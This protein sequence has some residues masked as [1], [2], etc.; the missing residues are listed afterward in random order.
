MNR[1]SALT[2]TL[3][4]ATF[5]ASQFGS[6]LPPI[7][8]TRQRADDPDLRA[9]EISLLVFAGL[10]AGILTIV[11]DSHLPMIGILGIAFA[12]IA[13]YEWALRTGDTSDG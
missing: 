9:T 10:F 1:D 8:E 6:H 7:Y 4:G 3:T 12:M 13:Y 5:I 2:I 11:T